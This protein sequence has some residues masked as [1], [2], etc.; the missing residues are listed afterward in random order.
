MKTWISHNQGIVVGI[1]ITIILMV[2]TFGCASQ[3]TSPIT[4]KLVTRPQL[5]LEVDIQ[6]KQLEAELDNLQAQAVLQ[7]TA[8]DRQDEIKSKLYEF[9]AITSNTNTFN[10]TGII[11]LAGTL[12]GLGA[13]ID[14]RIKDKVIKNRPLNNKVTT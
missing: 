1:I 4:G 3:V 2:W 13:G 6:V 10:P 7:F 5:T 12:L 8:L 14:N 11:T 9:A